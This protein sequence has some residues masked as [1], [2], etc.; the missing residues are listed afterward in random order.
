MAVSVNWWG[1]YMRAPTIS[2]TYEVPLMFGKL[3]HANKSCRLQ[4]PVNS[5]PRTPHI[6]EPLMTVFFG[7]AKRPHKHEDP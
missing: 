3:P 5:I 4:S 6:K 7:G 1:P 2:G